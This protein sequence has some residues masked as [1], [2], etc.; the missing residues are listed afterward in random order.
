[1]PCRFR[2]QNLMRRFLVFMQWL[3]FLIP[4]GLLGCALPVDRTES[5]EA[6]KLLAKIERGPCYGAC[7]IFSLAIYFDGTA[8]FHGTRNTKVM[9]ERVFTLT[10]NQLS[11]IRAAFTQKGFL[12]MNNNCC[13]CYEITDASSTIIT[14]QGNGPFKQ[15]EH[16]HGCNNWWSQK[17]SELEALVLEVTGVDKLVEE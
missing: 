9:G 14:Y 3:L 5:E 11:G 17:L 16:Y 1:M 12:I 4:L 15:I 2:A 13:D 6:P 10:D 7:P 8:V